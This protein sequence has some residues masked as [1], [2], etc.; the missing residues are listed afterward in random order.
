MVLTVVEGE[1]A[2]G[3][4]L[5]ALASQI[6]PPEMEVIV[7]FDSTV[8]EVANLA[9]RFLAFRFLDLGALSTKPSPLNEFDRH[10]LYDSRRA[11]GLCAATGALVAMVEDRGRPHQSWA[12]EMVNLHGDPELAAVGG[13]IENEA[14][15]AI[16]WAA[17]FCDFGRYQPPLSDKDPEYLSDINICYKRD[18]LEAV[19]GLWEQRYQETVVNWALRDKGQVLNL[20]DRPRVIHNRG[21]MTLGSTLSERVHWGRTFAQTRCRELSRVGRLLWAS[22]TPLLPALLFFRLARQQVGKKSHLAEFAIATPAMILML[23]FWSIG[24][25]IGYC[26]GAGATEVPQVA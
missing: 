6:D 21:P 17:F 10:V 12:R 3:R 2:L 20:S 16:R 8:S 9:E 18:A 26:E 24:E 11:G 4:C 23:L 13:A 1:P 22:A 14:A 25:F 19:R 5:E 7:P 15:G